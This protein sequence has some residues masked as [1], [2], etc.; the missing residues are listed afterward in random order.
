MRKDRGS[1][2]NTPTSAPPAS[3]DRALTGW[4]ADVGGDDTATIGK[5][6]KAMMRS[7][8]LY[9]AVREFSSW[10]MPAIRR[11]SHS[12]SD[13]PSSGRRAHSL[14]FVSAIVRAAAT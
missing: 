13:T 5:M 1:K 2:S 11:A 12:G 9:F 3:T 10:R 14:A 7:S 6:L 4:S 8:L